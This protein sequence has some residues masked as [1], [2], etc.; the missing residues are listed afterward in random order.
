MPG[1]RA[2]TPAALE[3][4]IRSSLG[5]NGP[6]LIEVRVGEMPSPWHL[7]RLK[8]MAGVKTQPAPPNPLP[9]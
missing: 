1:V 9:A 8:P 5:E 2:D 3:S 7:L 6:V 4:A